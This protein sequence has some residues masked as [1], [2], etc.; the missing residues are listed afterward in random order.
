MASSRLWVAVAA[1]DVAGPAGGRGQP[2]AARTAQARTARTTMASLVLWHMAEFYGHP[3]GGM[4]AK[5]WADA[6]G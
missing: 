3:G 6:R 2:I 1:A 5:T 4:H